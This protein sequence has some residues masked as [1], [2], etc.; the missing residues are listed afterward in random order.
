[1]SQKGALFPWRTIS[2]E[3][4]SA[5]YEAGTAQYHINADVVYGIDTYLKATGDDSVLLSH[6]IE[7]AVETARFW[8]DL[9]HY[10]DGAF[11]FSMVTGPD[12][13]SALVDDNAYTNYMARFNLER[14]VRMGRMGRSGA[15]VLYASAPSTRSRRCR[16]RA[17]A[18]VDRLTSICPGR[19]S[20]PHRTVA[21]S[22]ASP[23]TGIP[24]PTSIRSSSISTRW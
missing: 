12:E 24:R 1:M 18:E 21:S 8:A 14:A 4:A 3:E 19:V 11:H 22:S 6:G 9:G 13:Y 16:D 23:G 7:I 17:L 2:G 5:Y 10:R 20:S 15:S